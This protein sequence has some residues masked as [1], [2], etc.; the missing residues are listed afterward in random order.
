[1]SEKKKNITKSERAQLTFPVGKVQTLIKKT[2]PPILKVGGHTAIFIAAIAE[3]MTVEALE[4]AVQK[5]KASKKVRISSKHL[6]QALH[7]D[8]EL[9]KVFGI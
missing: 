8:D 5:A 1:M 2:V 4:V 7:D 9:R 3:L 6:M